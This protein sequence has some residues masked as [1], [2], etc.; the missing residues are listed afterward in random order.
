MSQRGPT[1]PA[2]RLAALAMAV[3][4]VF[5]LAG[6]GVGTD[7]RLGD[8]EV[9]NVPVVLFGAVPADDRSGPPGT[10]LALTFE[11]LT[12]ETADWPAGFAAVADDAGPTS[13]SVASADAT[14]AG[15]N[16]SAETRTHPDP[17]YVVVLDGVGSDSVRFTLA[18]DERT[19][20]TVAVD[21]DLL[22]DALGR[23]AFDPAGV[24]L[25]IDGVVTGYDTT[26]DGTVRFRT[27]DWT[28]RT[29][30]FRAVES[31]APAPDTDAGTPTEGPDG[32]TDVSTETTELPTEAPNSTAEKAPTEAGPTEAPSDETPP[33]G[34]STEEPADEA[35]TEGTPVQTPSAGTPTGDPSPEQSA[36]DSQAETPPGD[37]GTEQSDPSDVPETT[38]TDSK[39]SGAPDT[40]DSSDIEPSDDGE[41]VDTEPAGTPDEA[42]E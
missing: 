30:A 21:G 24:E 29:V 14:G 9:A 5:A 38:E 11:G 18:G 26:R 31:G 1:G 10:P 34:T 15:T 25:R 37:T 17:T 28:D 27:P 16:G 40:S 7:A 6:G 4:L 33:D 36:D 22:A 39:S 35:P 19:S 32:T 12:S 3:V 20:A 2:G 42:G 23:P 41:P 8:S 13:V